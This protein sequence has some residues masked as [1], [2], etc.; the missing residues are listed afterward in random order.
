MLILGYLGSPRL[1]GKCSHLLDSALEGAASSGATVKKIELVKKDIRHCMGCCKCLF[2]DPA[3]PIGRCLLKDEMALLLE[4]YITADG[5]I[6]ASPV[7]DLCITSLMKK[8]LER[9]IALTHR[10]QDAYATIGAARIPAEFKKNAALIVTGNCADEYSELMGDPCFEALE[11]HLIVEQVMTTDR[12]Y[13]GGVENM[14]DATFAERIDTAHR[15]G[16][17]LVEEIERS[18]Q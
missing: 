12:L 11:A 10:P 16:A 9:K 3:L 8:F 6:F 4:E 18:R 5:Y 2:D 13:V 14:T 15:M 1:K 7:Y 17:R